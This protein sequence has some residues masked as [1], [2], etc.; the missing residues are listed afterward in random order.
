MARTKTQKQIIGYTTSIKRSDSWERVGFLFNNRQEARTFLA[1]TFPK[2]TA[3][4]QAA[5]VSLTTRL[6]GASWA[7]HKA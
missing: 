1:K 7:D 5:R 3:K 4:I 6:P 2:L